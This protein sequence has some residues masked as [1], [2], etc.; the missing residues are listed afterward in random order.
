MTVA[1]S[2]EKPPAR[3]IARSAGGKDSRKSAEK[4]P[5]LTGDVDDEVDGRPA[6][7]RSSAA[8]SVRRKQFRRQLEKKFPGQL[9][10]NSGRFRGNYERT[11]RVL[12]SG[13]FKSTTNLI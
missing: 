11:N 6:L 13:N 7:R 5:R 1:F 3:G 2:E 9:R 4:K 10:G 8:A 12:T